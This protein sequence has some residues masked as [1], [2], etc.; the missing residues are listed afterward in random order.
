MI[1]PQHVAYEVSR[2]ALREAKQKAVQDF[3]ASVDC[4]DSDD[5][6]DIDTAIRCVD[7]AFDL[8]EQAGSFH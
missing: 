6:D 8:C 3:L 4:Y 5:H 7:Q 2:N 1:D